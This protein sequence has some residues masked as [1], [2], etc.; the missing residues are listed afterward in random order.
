MEVHEC[1]QRK[2]TA[3]PLEDRPRERLVRNGAASLSNA[4]L[5]AILLRTGAQGKN[6]SMLAKEFCEL[7]NHELHILTTFHQD[8]LIE[9][10]TKTKKSL[11]PGL[12]LDK[13]TTLLAAMEFGRRVYKPNKD[14]MKP[15]KDPVLRASQI[16]NFMFSEVAYN[17]E[18]NFWAIYLD[19]KQSIIHD[20]P[21]QITRGLDTH[22]LIDPKSIFKPAC[23]L[24]ASSVIIVH[25]HP[26]GNV[27]PSEADIR[28]TN[29]LIA[30]GKTIG[31]PIKDHIIIGRA[32]IPPH[33]ASLRAQDVCQ[34]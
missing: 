13:V 31:I 34:F 2:M 3:I 16:A 22:T 29:H 21:F 15:L 12:G 18:E 19:A 20:K 32:N 7:F 25:N 26:S 5:I 6:V 4:E 17:A 8:A 28:T 1:D 24:N 30:A 14:E 9:Y 11:L 23:M 10:L 27:T 33:Y